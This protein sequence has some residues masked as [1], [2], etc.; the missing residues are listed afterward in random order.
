MGATTI[1]A[2]IGGAVDSMSGD[3]DE[4]WDGA[5]KGAIIANVA[6]V[7]LPMA[8]TYAVGWAVL[9]GTGLIV[10]RAFNQGEFK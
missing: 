4:S 3:D 7:V 5:L 10:D 9:R 2:L 6:K 1:G 8:F